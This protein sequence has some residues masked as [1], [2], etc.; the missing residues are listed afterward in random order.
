M[1]RMLRHLASTALLLVTPLAVSAQDNGAIRARAALERQPMLDTMKE[2]VEIESG[3]SDYEGVTR[4]GQVIAGKLRA[5]GGEV[6]MVAPPA[7]MPRFSSTPPRLADSIVAR[8]RGTGTSRILLLAHMDTVYARGSLAQQPFRIDGDRAY[9]LG[10]ADDKHG[11]ALILHTLSTL[12]AVGYNGYG[13]LTV[14]INASEEVASPSSRALIAQLG[15][16]HDIVLS[17]EG[18][19][20]PTAPNVRL[21]TTGIQ[22]AILTVKGRASH[23]GAAPEQGRNALY[24]LSH[25]ILQMRD[26]SDP[27]KDVKVNWTISNAGSVFNA[28]PADARAVADMRAND[29]RDFAAVEAEMRRRIQRTLIPDTT[30]T[31]QFEPIF[32][33][34]PLREVSQRAALQARQI[35]AETGGTIEV[36]ETA[37]GGGTDAAFAAQRTQ[38]PVIEGFGLQGFGAHSSDSEY[39]LISSIEPR[40]YLL[41]RMIIEQSRR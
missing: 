13:T 6:T 27:S 18:G 22:N 9:G 14:M 10:I 28:I 5:L 26:L 34:L 11:V 40:L 1:P 21:A 35:Y 30:T 32:P 8:F 33:P 41:S 2:L 16:E 3:S 7:D 36:R 29:P 25:H 24:E 17:C 38:A 37:T 31:L 23:A 39:V 15:S 20:S 4:I 19:G 12:R